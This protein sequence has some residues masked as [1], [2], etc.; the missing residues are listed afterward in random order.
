MDDEECSIFEHHTDCSWHLTRLEG[1]VL[2][3]VADSW[4]FFFFWQEARHDH[5][6]LAP[7]R[8]PNAQGALGA[9]AYTTDRAPMWP[10]WRRGGGAKVWWIWHVSVVQWLKWFFLSF[11]H[12]SKGNTPEFVR[13]DVYKIDS[14]LICSYLF[15]GGEYT[16]TH[17]HTHLHSELPDVISL[18]G[19]WRCWRLARGTTT[20]IWSSWTTA[21]V[22]SRPV[23]RTLFVR[24]VM[25]RWIHSICGFMYTHTHTRARAHTHTHTQ[26]VWA[27]C[28]WHSHILQ[29][30]LSWYAPVSRLIIIV[31]F[32]GDETRLNWESLSPSGLQNSGDEG[33][34][35]I[36]CLTSRRRNE[37]EILN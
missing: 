29:S 28:L 33:T 7:R 22:C 14:D 6:R 4:V 26:C 17:T 16:H 30:T 15:F 35:W 21:L 8:G 18:R 1:C 12:R 23:T 9:E 27:V 10:W 11:S 19:I 2:H 20:L 24:N 36:V 3:I 32:K 34:L 5:H 25:C 13:L 31:G 37:S